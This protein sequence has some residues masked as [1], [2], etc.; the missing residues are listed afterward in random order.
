DLKALMRTLPPKPEPPED[1]SC[2]LTGCEFCV[3]DLYD[4]DMREYQQ[5]AKAISEEFEKQGKP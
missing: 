3:W 1:D 4:D 2:C 5:Q